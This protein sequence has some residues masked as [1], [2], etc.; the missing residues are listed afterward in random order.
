[1]ML[2]EIDTGSCVGLMSGHAAKRSHVE[3][4]FIN[5]TVPGL[6]LGTPKPSADKEMESLIARLKKRGAGP[7]DSTFH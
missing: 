5:L 6:F 3:C 7:W 2:A 4:Q 1:M